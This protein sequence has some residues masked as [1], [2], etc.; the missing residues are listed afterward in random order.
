MTHILNLQVIVPEESDGDDALR[1]DPV[2]FGSN[3]SLISCPQSV[4]SLITCV[5]IG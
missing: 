4:H 5:V 2:A 3:L 1:F